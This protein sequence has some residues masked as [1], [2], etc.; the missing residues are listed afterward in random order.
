MAINRKLLMIGLILL[1]INMVMATQYAVTKVEYEYNIV[2]PSN[3][4]IRYI[5]ADNSSDNIRVL[6]VEGDNVSMVSVKLRLGGNFTINQKKIYTAAFGI[7]NEEEYTVNITHINVTSSNWTYMKIWLHGDRDVNVE[8]PTIDNTS[9][10]MYNNGT[11]VN[12]SNTTAWSLAAGDK[13]P[14]T[15]CYNI[16][17]RASCTVNTT[18]DDTA[19]VRYSLNN[20]NATSEISDFVWVQIAIDIGDVADYLGP[21]TGDIYIYLE[22]EN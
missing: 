5:G 11:I 7:V 18:W 19:H 4:D 14:N 6:R 16:S 2:H 22:S 15:M 3:A 12:A 8:P 13:N 9:V 17:D 10:Y 21:H 20:S 1:V